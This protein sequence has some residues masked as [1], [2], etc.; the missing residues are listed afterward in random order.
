MRVIWTFM[1]A[2]VVAAAAVGA[3][4]AGTAADAAPLKTNIALVA[5][6]TPKEAYAKIIDAFGDTAAGKNASFTQSYSG[7]TEQAAAVVA[8]LSADVV[9]LSL[10]P[11]VTTLVNAGKV[12]KSW[13]KD[14]YGGMVTDSI[15]VFVVRDNNPKKIHGWADLVKP[16][17][18]VITPNPV[19]SGGAR[20]NIMAAYGA[21]RK[22]G[23]SH[24]QAV[25]YMRQ[26]FRHVPVMAA[27]AR[28]AL[29]TFA[30]GKGDVL[31][32]Y[33]NEAIFAN[34]KGIRTDFVRPRETILIENPVALT[35]SGA[36]KKEAKAFVHFLR[37]PTAQKLYA[38]SGFR[39]VVKS[40]L[41]ETSYP[42]PRGLFKI[43]YMG[44]WA[45]VQK[46]FFAPRTGI[47]TK[48]IAGLGK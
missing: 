33:E 27:S 11:D 20:W 21:E 18:E 3:A 15:V 25:A 48:I 10:E 35:K 38:E 41:R 44:G 37:T 43:G 12:P 36:K 5:Y 24:K 42:T 1:A 17:I 7:S 28:E 23:K 29:Q 19:T 4:V 2:A 30:T 22:Q 47:V 45:K 6:S 40:V 14:K 16:G 31:L 8:G 46:Q 9:A 39:P 34:R 32:T 26:L 13:K